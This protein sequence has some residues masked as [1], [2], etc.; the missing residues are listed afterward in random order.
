MVVLGIKSRPLDA[1]FSGSICSVGVSSRTGRDAEGVGPETQEEP[2]T[3][4]QVEE[5]VQSDAFCK[6]KIQALPTDNETLRDET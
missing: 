5:Q 2:S 4:G 6:R 3:G 1:L